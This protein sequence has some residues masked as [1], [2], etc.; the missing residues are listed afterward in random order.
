MTKPMTSEQ[1]A[2][3]HKQL[4]AKIRRYD[5]LYYVDGAPEISDKEYDAIFQE[6]LDLEKQYPKVKAP[7][8][9]TQRV[10]GEPVEGLEHVTHGEYMLSIDN[11]FTSEALKTR[12]DKWVAE[13]KN[14]TP[15]V[16]IEPKIDGVAVSLLYTNGVLTGAVTRGNGSEG[17]NVLHSARNMIGAVP[18][19]FHPSD[20]GFFNGTFVEVRG[21]AYI[22]SRDFKRDCGAMEARGEEPHKHSRAA[23]AGAL[24]NLDPR[25]TWKRHVRFAMHGLGT[26]SE[27]LLVDNSWDKTC[28][29]LLGCGIVGILAETPEAYTFEMLTAEVDRVREFWAKTSTPVDGIV[30]KL[31]KFSDR[32]EIGTSSRAV[33]WAIAVKKD[34][35]A[36]VTTVTKL[37][38]QVGKLGTLTPVCFMKPV[39]IDNTDV[40]KS[41]LHNFEEVDE[42]DIRVGDEILVE[43]AGKIIPHILEVHYDKRP[44]GTKK[45]KRPTKCPSCGS[46]VVQD[47]V[48]VKCTNTFGCKAQL[49]ALILSAADRTR[50]NIDGLGPTLIK[51]LIDA[52]L[53]TSFVD[54]WSLLTKK[55]KLLKLEG[56]GE[57]TVTKLLA[58]LEAAKKRGPDKLLSC[59][60]IPGLGRT[61]A[62]VL[63]NTYGT[64]D[65]IAKLPYD[66]LR[67]FIGHVCGTAVQKWFADKKN[68]ILISKFK[69]LGFDFGKPCKHTLAV[70][71]P[72]TGKK[73]CATGT[74]EKYTRE[75][76][77]D[78]IEAAGGTVTVVDL[79]FSVRPPA[80]GNQHQNR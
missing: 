54:L 44:E 63:T 14:M 40:T 57:K 65:E 27:K 17:D 42:L 43:K 8:S 60:L 3:K 45:F 76:I 80:A 38:V 13:L 28:V 69:A 74:F 22:D 33:T 21:E 6:L 7:D 58:E 11:A 52:N 70:Q 29:M 72:L 35:Y 56:V 64:I 30:V 23:A 55:A 79:P 51:Q 9:P 5:R 66:D 68:L 10:G 48:A 47:G 53:V 34:L 39:E 49:Q 77:H 37:A 32:D 78:A 59:L 16:R 67:P 4:C 25:E 75:S 31:D 20:P 61:K 50:L 12:W 73:V 2:E 1:V 15:T 18:K 71:G 46:A 62:K 41:T 24:R 19:L 36:A 26:V